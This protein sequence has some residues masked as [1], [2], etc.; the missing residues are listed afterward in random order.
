MARSAMGLDPTTLV[1]Q[2]ECELTSQVTSVDRD[3]VYPS[4]YRITFLMLYLAS[5]A[6]Q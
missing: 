1:R 3:L 5:F 6:Y 4:P 2:E